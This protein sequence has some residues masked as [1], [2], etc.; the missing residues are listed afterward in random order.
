VICLPHRA[1]TLADIYEDHVW[2]VYG[3]FGYHGLARQDAEDLTQLTFERAVRAYR[4]YD[5][6]RAGV[7]TWLIAIAQNLLIDHY[8]RESSRRHRSLDAD[9]EE[10][11]LG[12]HPG[13]EA[14]LG[15]SPRL[16][17]ALETLSAREREV[18]ALRFGGDLRGPEIAALLNLSLANVQQIA[19]RALRRL[20]AEIEDEQRVPAAIGELS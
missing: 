9:L 10:E 18:I 13:P 7:K 12:S 8:R 4:R 5:P 6:A 17:A 14:R 11:Q 1:K 2:H 15:L 19:S 16:A 3:F 20:R